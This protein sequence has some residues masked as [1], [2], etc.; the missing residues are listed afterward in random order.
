VP[1]FQ[2]YVNRYG[3]GLVIY[4]LG[5]VDELASSQPDVALAD[6]F[7]DEADIQ[8]LPALPLP[9]LLPPLSAA[10]TPAAMPPVAEEAASSASEGAPA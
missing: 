9:L 7:P 10:A 4:W 2:A 6:A 8:R 3:P 5:Y 1:Q